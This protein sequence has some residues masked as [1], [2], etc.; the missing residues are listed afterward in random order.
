MKDLN[1]NKNCQKN[2]LQLINYFFILVVFNSKKYKKIIK[3]RTKNQ[4]LQP[5]WLQ[6][7]KKVVKNGQKT[8]RYKIKI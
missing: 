5:K 6:K 1:K 7:N 8:K 3:N 4:S 2:K